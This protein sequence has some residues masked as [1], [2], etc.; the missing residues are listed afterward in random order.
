MSFKENLLKKIKIDR[1]SKVVFA[2]IG[3]PDSGKKIDKEKMR[4]LLEMSPYKFRHE[5]DLDLYIKEKEVDEVSEKIDHLSRMITT[6]MK[7]LS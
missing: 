6:L 2:S 5:R 7:K 1:I 3:T 4:E